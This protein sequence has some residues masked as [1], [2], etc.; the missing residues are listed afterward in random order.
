MKM[1]A[2]GVALFV[3]FAGGCA[4]PDQSHFESDVR[5]AIHDG[6]PVEDAVAALGRLNLHCNASGGQTARY[7]CSRIESHLLFSCVPRVTFAADASDRLMKNAE[8]P[9]IACAGM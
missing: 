8:I 6:M 2:C 9:K 3:F 7:D 1:I 4:T 5:A